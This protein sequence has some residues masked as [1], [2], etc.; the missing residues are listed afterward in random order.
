MSKTNR[1]TSVAT[2]DLAAAVTEE[3][4]GQ[5]LFEALRSADS[6]ADAQQ[7]AWLDHAVNLVKNGKPDEGL[8]LLEGAE[9][10]SRLDVNMFLQSRLAPK[11]LG[12][13]ERILDRYARALGTVGGAEAV[14]AYRKAQAKKAAAGAAEVVVAPAAAAA[15]VAAPTAASDQFEAAAAALGAAVFVI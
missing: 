5:T 12:Q 4:S 13:I 11:E 10:R 1:S 3:E 7:Q 8:A 2:A 15:P 9:I 6:T 14:V